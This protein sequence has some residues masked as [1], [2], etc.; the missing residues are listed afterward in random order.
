MLTAAHC[1]KGTRRADYQLIVGRTTL[2]RAGGEV[3]R[4][5]RQFIN[6]NYHGE[7]Y[8]VALVKLQRAAI[9]TPAPVADDSLAAQWAPGNYLLSSGW[10]YTCAAETYACQGDHL[11]SGQMRVRSDADCER[12][13]APIDGATEICT[14]T[15]NLSLGSGD[16]GGP[17]VISTPD[18]PRLV[19]VNSWGEVD[20]QNRDVVGGWMGYAEVAGT[21]LATWIADKIAA[22]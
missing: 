19:A 14:K 11:K 3:I 13:E 8:D 20:S 9:E 22:N 4:P 7:G 5:A 12:A 2:T 6:P 21:S 17:A 18:G 15:A 16:S 10:G 1:L